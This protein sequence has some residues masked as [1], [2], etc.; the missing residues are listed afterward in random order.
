MT[1]AWYVVRSQPN[2]EARAL[3]N[4]A[5]QGFEA[6]LPRYGATRRHARRVERVLRPLFPRYLFVR[7]DPL[8]ARW[9]ALLSTYGVASLVRAGEQPAPVPDGVVEAIRRREDG[10][11][12][13][14]L[15]APPVVPGQAVRLVD[16][17][18]A[19]LVGRVLSLPDD[20]RVVLLLSL[21]GREVKV[22]VAAHQL[23]A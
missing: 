3:A 10:E 22:A 1:A 16:G 15:P 6:Y 17:P 12:L 9:R 5:R 14:R 7:F 13:I 8:K 21:L 18:F 19:D 23:R 4:I 2:G 20:D 11:G